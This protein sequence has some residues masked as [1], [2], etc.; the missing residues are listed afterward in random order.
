MSDRDIFE[1]VILYILLIFTSFFTLYLCSIFCF[2]KKKRV[3]VLQS[4]MCAI[5]SL[6]IYVR[7]CDLLLKNNSDHHTT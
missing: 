3:T 2:I 4:S 1:G 6:S 5:L 7:T